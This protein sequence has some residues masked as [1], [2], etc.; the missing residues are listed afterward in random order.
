MKYRSILVGAALMAACQDQTMTGVERRAANAGPQYSI[1]NSNADNARVAI[2]DVVGRI[3]P[4]LS[5][6][7]A[8]TGLVA[9]I[10]GLQQAVDAGNAADAPSLARA[11]LAE[12][13]RYARSTNADAA[14]MD[15]IRLALANLLRQ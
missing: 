8:A 1:E 13:D 12:L 2:D 9:A 5:D 7:T 11:A 10:S 15:A 3:I 6:A 4:A 14:D